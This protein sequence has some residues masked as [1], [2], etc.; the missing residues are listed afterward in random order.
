M[1]LKTF[2]VHLFR[3]ENAYLENINADKQVQP[4]TKQNTSPPQKKDM[5]ITRIKTVQRNQ[6]TNKT[7]TTYFETIKTVERTA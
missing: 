6:P 1:V 3:K 2:D 7:T 5:K 4:K